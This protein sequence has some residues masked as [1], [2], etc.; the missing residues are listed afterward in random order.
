MNAE[1]TKASHGLGPLMTNSPPKSWHGQ[2]QR[3]LLVTSCLGIPAYLT[4][5]QMRTGTRI[6]RMVEIKENILAGHK[7]KLSGRKTR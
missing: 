2:T 5:H 7:A 6:F 3:L 4:G 1:M